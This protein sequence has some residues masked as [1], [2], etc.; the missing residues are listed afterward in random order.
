[1]FV[2]EFTVLQTQLLLSTLG[3]DSIGPG[4][5]ARTIMMGL[6]QWQRRG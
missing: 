3:V 1:M 4:D 5:H 2:E 6:R